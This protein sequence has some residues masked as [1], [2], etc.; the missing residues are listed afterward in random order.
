MNT[1]RSQFNSFFIDTKNFF[2]NL[3]NT[4][5]NFLS[6]YFDDTTLGIFGIVLG[7]LAIVFGI[8]QIRKKQEKG[9]A[10]GGIV[11]GSI[12]I[13]ISAIIILISLIVVENAGTSYYDDYD[14][15]DSFL[16]DFNS[17]EYKDI[18]LYLN[19]L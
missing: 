7:I 12:A 5:Y 2:I 13:V 19:D 9:M 10:I 11:T 17:I 18:D 15:Y 1:I 8:L 16:E 14:Y 4:I 6:N 3:Y